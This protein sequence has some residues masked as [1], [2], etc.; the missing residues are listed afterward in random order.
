VHA[1][2]EY[3]SL[4]NCAKKNHFTTTIT[5]FFFFEHLILNLNGNQII[6][7]VYQS[8][9]KEKVVMTRNAQDRCANSV[10]A[11]MTSLFLFFCF[12]SFSYVYSFQFCGSNLGGL[13]S[14]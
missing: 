13:C 9:V 6:L 5:I 7:S 12:M 3:H 4:L 8:G 1:C 10:K 11:T 2:K 14:C